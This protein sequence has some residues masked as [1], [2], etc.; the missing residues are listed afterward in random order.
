[1]IVSRN[2]NVLF[3]T[4]V[5]SLGGANRSM[6]QLILELRDRHGISPYVLI[7]DDDPNSP[8]SSVLADKGIEF[9][10]GHYR[11][12][13]EG[14]I[15]FSTKISYVKLLLNYQS[16]FEKL[17]HLKIDLVH[18]NSSVLDI[19]C[20]LSKKFRVKHVMHLREFGDLDFGIK[21]IL[22][23]YYNRMVYRHCDKLIAISN[24]IYRHFMEV[25]PHDR[26]HLIY[27][28]LPDVPIECL[29]KHNNDQ[30][31]F[32]CVGW[33]NENK[34]QLEILRAVDMLV[35]VH[36]C[37]QF[38][39]TIVGPYSSDY[40]SVMT[41][42][43]EQS[44]IESYVSIV[45]EQRNVRDILSRM[46]V[47][48]TPS[49]S[50]AFGRTTV[51]YMLHSLAVIVNDAGANIELVPSCHVGYIYQFGVFA[52]LALHMKNL[53]D[54]KRIISELGEN[55]RVHAKEHFSSVKNADGVFEL[56]C[57]LLS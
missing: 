1:M 18:S 25:A 57:E 53:I 32:V 38:H 48:I 9:F 14:Y 31:Q 55:G 13:K 41:K 44:N 15:P 49:N 39:L 34:N 28:G 17:A 43:I 52:E 10:V 26:I 36:K 54:N 42:F 11:R 45:G 40:Y 22:G 7:P 4:H 51:E 5:T 24:A 23:D 6:I 46:D 16:I 33:V 8:I 47:G 2:L 29:S 19:G 3:V 27:N 35:N 20:F 50:E 37:E 12:Y 30:V 21:S 56:Y